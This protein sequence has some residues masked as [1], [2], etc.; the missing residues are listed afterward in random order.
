MPVSSAS[1]AAKGVPTT[2]TSHTYGSLGTVNFEIAFPLYAALETQLVLA[3][4]ESLGIVMSEDGSGAEA[5]FAVRWT[6]T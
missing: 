4:G 5:L 2:S 3:E 1:A 6:E